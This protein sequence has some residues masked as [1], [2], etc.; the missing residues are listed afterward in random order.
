MNIRFDDDFD[1]VVNIKV[2]GVGGGGG[3]ALDYMISSGIKNVEYIS[4]NTDVY[5]LKNSKATQRVQIGAKLTKGR[6]AGNKPEIGQRSAEESREEIAAALKGAN[7]VFITAGMGGGTGTGA[8]P[9]VAEIAR[10]LDILTVSVVTKPFM[11]ER[12]Q[13]MK[14][15]EKGIANLRSHVDSLVIIPNE[16]LLVGAEKPLTMKESFALSDEV[17]WKAVKSISDL[18]NVVGYINLDFS[19]VTTIMKDAGIAHMAMGSGSG[20]NKS[21]E[22]ANEVISSPLLETSLAGAGKILANIVMS[23]DVLSD[24]VDTLSKLITEAA[25][26]DA[27]VIIGAVFDETLEDEILV[28]VIATGFENDESC[29]ED[30]EVTDADDDADNPFANIKQNTDTASDDD[31]F[32]EIM[33]LFKDKS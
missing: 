13:K 16:R 8:A 6:G 9:V 15:A 31:S 19:D 7:M 4:I 24:E 1:S 5:A 20:K 33:K 21:E 2:L 18:I 25:Q 3:N 11:F 32:T 27:E 23:E 30:G 26:P 22:A 10:E 28:T 12:E 29:G 14:Q 17:L